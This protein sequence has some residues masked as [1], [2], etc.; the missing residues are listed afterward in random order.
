MTITDAQLKDLKGKTVQTPDG[1]GK[2]TEI[3]DRF[4]HLDMPDKTKRMFEP[5]E[6]TLVEEKR[7]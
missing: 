1:P 2:V 5:R 4:I 3:G 7:K 6:L